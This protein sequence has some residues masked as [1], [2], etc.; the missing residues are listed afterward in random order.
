MNIFEDPQRRAGQPKGPSFT[1]RHTAEHGG[2]LY[3]VY[4]IIELARDLPVLTIPMERLAKMREGKYWHD[5]QGNWAGPTEIIELYEQTNGDWDAMVAK[6]PELEKHI[7][8]V[9][10]ADYEL[11]PL[12]TVGP[13][14]EEWV[15]DGMHRLT[16]AWIDKIAE[17][18]IKRFDSLPEEAVIKESDTKES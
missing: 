1:S 9:Q 6:R 12:I 16:K 3:D 17:I 4:K 7:R 18:S 15:I 10:N 13:E 11:Y 14:G 8:S 2:K 5:K